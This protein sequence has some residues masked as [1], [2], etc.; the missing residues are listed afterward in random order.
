MCIE[1]RVR[2]KAKEPQADSQGKSIECS[3]V[4]AA[5][6]SSALAKL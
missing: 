1:K 4:A 6:A 3:P 2:L 5:D